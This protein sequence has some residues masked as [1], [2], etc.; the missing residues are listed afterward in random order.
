[1]NVPE[2]NFFLKFPKNS[3]DFRRLLKTFEEDP[4]LFGSYTNE[5]KYNSRDKLDISEIIDIFFTSE[6]ME[7]T[8]LESWMYFGMNFTSSVFSSKTLVSI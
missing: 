5:F 3:E 8:P 7:N 2:H 4:K 1:M 6:G